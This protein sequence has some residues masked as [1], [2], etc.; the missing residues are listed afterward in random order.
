MADETKDGSGTST[1]GGVTQGLG[2]IVTALGAYYSARSVKYLARSRA[3]S[4]EFQGSIAALN[5]QQAQRDA[6]ALFN[7]ARFEHLRLTLAAGEDKAALTAMQGSS[8]FQAGDANS[9]E[10]LA[11]RELQKQ[12]DARQLRIGRTQAY[13]AAM[14]RVVSLKNDE[15]FSRTNAEIAR[16]TARA[17]SPGA[18]FHIG[19]ATGASSWGAYGG[20]S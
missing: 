13:G 3:L 16:K 1:L 4:M 19:L 15:A 9:S 12:M 14:S 6:D 17:I 8:G 7:S 5:A 11:S 18:A 10:V 20:S 2:Q